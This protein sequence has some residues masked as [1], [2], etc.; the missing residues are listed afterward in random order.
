MNKKIACIIGFCLL[1]STIA[2][3]EQ[4]PQKRK[5]DVVTFWAQQQFDNVPPAG[6]GA[7]AI[8]FDLEKDWHFYASANTAPGGM[9]LKIEPNEQG[10]T[11]IL[12]F[13]KPIWPKSEKFYDPALDVNL[14]VFSGRFTVYL[15]FTVAA[16]SPEKTVAINISIDG[17][18]CSPVQCRVPK[19]GSVPSVLKIAKDAV[20]SKPNFELPKPVTAASRTTVAAYSL[21]AALILAFVAGLS[22]NIMPC[23]WPVLP[24]IVMRLVD[25]AKKG[26]SASLVMGLAFCLGILLFF[27][28]LAGA[29]IVLQVFYGTVLQWGDQFRNPGFLTAMAMLLVVLAL[30]MF[31]LFTIN[32]PSSLAGSAGSGQGLGGAVGMGFLAAILSTPCSF[33]I[34]AAA[35]AWAQ[36]QPLSLAT[37][38]IMTIGIGM[39]APY[40]ILTAIPALLQKAPRP[41]KWMELFKQAIGFI[42]LGIALKLIAALP[43]G[44]QINVLYFALVASFC[45]WMWAGW[46]DYS[47]P[48]L[49]KWIIRIIAVII[50][51]TA[52][53]ELLS[54]AKPSLID[55]QKYDAG[56]IKADLAENRPVLIDFTAEWCLSCKLVDKTVYSR[57]DIVELLKQKGVVAVKADTTLKDYPATNDLKNIYNEPGVPVTILLIPGQQEP[58]RWRG[59]TFGDD[60]KS[61]LEKLR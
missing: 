33:G 2:F 17:A 7:V 18:V 11:H 30:F 12:K 21:W 51:V 28:A 45:V 25:Q 38:T 50:A 22:L 19:F 10:G 61:A 47:T 23:V 41:G 49:R 6:K 24:I 59:I 57:K 58:M 40:L 8:H 46:V 32:I 39:A 14:D 29:N 35:F 34:L 60:L 43:A 9:N 15:P 4:F 53:F 42:L 26:K 20:L 55:W 3:A 27:A 36:T 5:V 13:D 16:D 1:L 31:G 37:L 56:A 54:P 52:G 44:S 48:A